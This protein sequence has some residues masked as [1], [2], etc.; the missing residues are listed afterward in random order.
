MQIFSEGRPRT[1][2]LTISELLALFAVRTQ[3]KHLSRRSTN[4]SCRQFRQWPFLVHDHIRV[5]FDQLLPLILTKIYVN[6]VVSII[7]LFALF[8]LEIPHSG[9]RPSSSK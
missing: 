5:A 4:T 2:A 1:L 8:Q 3:T 9:L 6:L 7:N